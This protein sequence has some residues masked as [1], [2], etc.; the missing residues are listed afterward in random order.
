MIAELQKKLEELNIPTDYSSLLDW[1]EKRDIIILT[2]WSGDWIAKV[3]FLSNWT[4]NRELNWYH[5]YNL[6]GKPTKSDTRW[7]AIDKLVLG[8]LNEVPMKFLKDYE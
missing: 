4:N 6:S 1:F 7:E 2:N 5:M 3:Y 8:I